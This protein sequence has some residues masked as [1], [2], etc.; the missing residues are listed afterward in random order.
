MPA[1]VKSLKAILGEHLDWHGARLNF[2]A[3]F[4]L[5]L[6]KV[7]TVNLAQVA[8]AF[9]G[10]AKVESNYKRLQRFFRGFSI[11]YAVIA[12]L[13]ARLVPVEGPWYLTIDRTNWK[14]GKA[15]INILVL[16][17]AYQGIA[18]PL[19]WSLLPKAGNSNTEERIEL[20]ER[21][22]ALFGR[23]QIIALLADRE[24]IG[25]DWFA[26][27]RTQQ[28]A[29]RIRI[30]EDTLVSTRQG[31]GMNAWTLFRDLKANQTRILKGKREIMGCRLHLVGMK[32]AN[33]EFLLVATTDSP[34]K[35]LSDYARRWEI[36]TLFGC[37]KS[38]GFCFED[39]HLTNPERIA[40][41]V[42]LLAIAFAWAYRTGE[43]LHTQKPIPFKKLCNARSKADSDTASIILGTSSSISTKNGLISV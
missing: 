37:L 26:Y 11:N 34:S 5:A 40:K 29:F 23:E 43:W 4:I 25:R 6:F 28:I 20:I 30:K 39:T 8:T 33:S 41:L 7:K 21:F 13:M 2:L 32:L 17:I 19:L 22:L 42:A 24:F 38:R 31:Y 14:F 15:N 16:G 1:V 27:L 3:N 35:A 10:R 18:F 9:S 12:R 36:E